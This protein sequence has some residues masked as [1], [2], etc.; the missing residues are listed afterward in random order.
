[1][2]AD[3]LPDRRPPAENPAYSL[4]R[5]ALFWTNHELPEFAIQLKILSHRARGLSETDLGRYAVILGALVA[6]NTFGTLEEA[7]AYAQNHRLGKHALVHKMEDVGLQPDEIWSPALVVDATLGLARQPRKHRNQVFTTMRGIQ[8][9]VERQLL[10][11]D[12]R[13]FFAEQS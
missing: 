11:P 4:R 5:S 12:A 8:T 7:V 1:M 9:A 2:N 6:H 3:T 10:H 13:N